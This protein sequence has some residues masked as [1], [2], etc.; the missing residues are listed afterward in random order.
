MNI[1][2]V[3]RDKALVELNL[4]N[5]TAAEILRV[6]LVAQGADFAAWR[7]EHPSKPVMLRIESEKGVGK[8][9]SAAVSALK[10]DLDALRS[11]LKK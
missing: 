8:A 3:T 1:E 4:D 11:G 5:A 10:K 2:V 9:V 7:R 6:Y